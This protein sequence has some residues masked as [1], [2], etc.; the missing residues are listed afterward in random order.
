MESKT[1]N[2]IRKYVWMYS[3]QNKFV[4]PITV[5]EL[6]KAQRDMKERLNKNR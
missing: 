3:N 2:A 6:V 4:N 1:K 5:E